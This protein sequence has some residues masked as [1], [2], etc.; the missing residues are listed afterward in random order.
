[1]KKI[2]SKLIAVLALVATTGVFSSCE[3][4]G[5]MSNMVVISGTGVVNHEATVEMESTLQLTCTE[6]ISGM[7]DVVWKSDDESIAKV[8]PRSGV[9]TPVAPG[10]VRIIVYTDTDIVPQS[11]FDFVFIT[12]VGKSLGVIDD[13]LDQSE[14]D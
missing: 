9:V 10:R 3:L 6:K 13:G 2:Y 5:N 14:A 7:N 8:D 11:D 4:L 12:V 1:M